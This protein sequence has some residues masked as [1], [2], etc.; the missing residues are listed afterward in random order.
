MNETTKTRILLINGEGTHPSDVSSALEKA[1]F[2]IEAIAPQMVETA[3]SDG[4]FDLVILD[5]LTFGE[6]ETQVLTSVSGSQESLP[7]IAVSPQLNA[8]ETRLLFKHKVAD[9]VN[10][11]LEKDVLIASIRGAVQ[12]KRFGRHQVHAVL[13]AVGGAGATTV[14]VSLADLIQTQ[15]GKKKNASIALFDLDFST[16]NCSYALDMPSDF[17]LGSIAGSPRRVDAEFMRVLRQTHENGFFLYSFKRPD[18]N[19]E[20]NGYELVLRMLDTVVME[21]DH[22]ILDIP[23]YETDWREDVLSAIN[24]CTIVSELNLPALK[25]TL[26]MAERIKELRGPSF[27]I[28][29]LFNKHRSSLFGQRIG[30]SKLKELFPDTPYYFLPQENDVLS[31]ALDRG[32]VPSEIKRG[33]SFTKR[34]RKYLNNIDLSHREEAA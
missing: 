6:N 2:A 25:H 1:N 14:A 29:I 28:N 9:W 8:A 21:H 12:T 33:N 26:E 18:L 11:P 20:L 17:N 15:Y 30:N 19:T 24:T 27:P 32:M 13:S 10:K 3:L 23:Y 4:V 31:E 34:L 16:G 5:F 22:T 7:V